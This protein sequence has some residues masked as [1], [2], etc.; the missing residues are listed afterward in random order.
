MS[1][2]IT[3]Q[4]AL[5][6]TT[7]ILL[8]ACKTLRVPEKHVAVPETQPVELWRAVV[9]EY[10]A[11][12]DY[13]N[14]IANDST[15]YMKAGSIK[16]VDLKTRKPIWTYAHR[17]GA[18]LSDDNA[19]LLGNRLYFLMGRNLMS[20]NV[21]TQKAKYYNDSCDLLREPPVGGYGR[22]YFGQNGPQEDEFLRCVDA[23]TGK[24]QW[25]TYSYSN[26]IPVVGDSLLVD[27]IYKKEIVAK[28]PAEMEEE[29]KE[30]GH[31]VAPEKE[32][33]V[34]YLAALHPITGQEVFSCKADSSEYYYEKYAVGEGRIVSL[35]RKSIAGPGRHGAWGYNFAHVVC[36]DRQGNELWR[37]DLGRAGERISQESAI[38]HGGRV[39]IFYDKTITL[40][41]STGMPLW[42]SELI[43]IRHTTVVSAVSNALLI[44]NDRVISA[45]NAKTGK[46]M[47][48]LRPEETAKEQKER[49]ASGSKILLCPD[50]INGTIYVLCGSQL[51]AYGQ[52]GVSEAK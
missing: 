14:L 31:P 32:V 39:Y 23:I 26:H 25:R 7:G 15:L 29:M 34:Q 4:I 35:C 37:Y 8:S 28:T 20:Y 50:I 51:I 27:I 24:T 48:E 52:G 11:Y 21:S 41:L 2:S 10:A 18:K 9:D 43:P 12:K 22:L 17:S 45:L 3:I 44:Q 30:L 36:L 13:N 40:D 38:I 49:G 47:W 5:L 46:L 1:K 42:T 6:L 33:Q 16:A 19:I